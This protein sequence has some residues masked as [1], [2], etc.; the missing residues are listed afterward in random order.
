MP[1]LT[2]DL[3]ATNGHAPG[4][5]D[6]GNNI[7]PRL[8]KQFVLELEVGVEVT[9]ILEGLPS[10]VLLGQAMPFD[11][12]VPDI[13]SKLCTEGALWSWKQLAIQCQR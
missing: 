13:P 10:R 7:S 4:I 2:A 11:E 5:M 1:P 6:A 12:H 8:R 9:K 3:L